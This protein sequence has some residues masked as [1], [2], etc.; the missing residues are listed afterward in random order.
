MS[1][2]RC[3]IV[4]FALLLSLIV[5]CGQQGVH[6]SGKVTFNGNP[7]PAGKIYFMPDGAKGNKGSTGYA[8]VKNGQY[9]TSSSGGKITPGGA[10]KVAIEGW[11][12]NLSAKG[13]KG[14]TSGEQTFQALFPQYVL[15]V[16]VGSSSGT[17]D[18][19]VPAS[20]AKRK[21]KTETPMINP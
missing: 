19:E 11:D 18:F 21:D 17:K 4:V 13:K 9:S 3:W 10:L 20:A 6:L 5:G 16:D 8:D 12:P 15:Q 1:K 7:L 14:D 2:I